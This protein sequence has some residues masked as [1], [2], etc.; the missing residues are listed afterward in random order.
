MNMLVTGT[1]LSSSFDIPVQRS[2]LHPTG[3]PCRAPAVVL[4]VEIAAPDRSMF[5]LPAMIGCLLSFGTGDPFL[6]SMAMLLAL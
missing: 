3:L 6:P 1:N 5:N 4:H 2:N